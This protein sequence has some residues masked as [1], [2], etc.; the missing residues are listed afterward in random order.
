MLL[1][2]PLAIKYD[3]DR[4]RLI[5]PPFM[6]LRMQIER[7]GSHPAISGLAETHSEALRRAK[8]VVCAC[9][10]KT[11]PREK[12]EGVHIYKSKGPARFKSMTRD[13]PMIGTYV[14]CLECT[15]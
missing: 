4:A 15:K 13:G 12:A 8:G 11:K 6:E 14:L 3:P 1:T 7:P 5:T 9:C 10:R 2:V